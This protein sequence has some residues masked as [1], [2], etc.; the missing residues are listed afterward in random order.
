MLPKVK[1]LEWGRSCGNQEKEANSKPWRIIDG[2]L[3][4]TQILMNK[5]K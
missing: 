3:K 1:H 2:T 4:E 5:L